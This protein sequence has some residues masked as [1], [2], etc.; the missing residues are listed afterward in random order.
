VQW[1]N[2]KK[3][4]LDTTSDL[5]VEVERGARKLWIAQEVLSKMGEGRK[6][7]DVNNEEE[8]KNNR[9]ALNFCQSTRC[10]SIVLIQAVVCL[11]KVLSLKMRLFFP[12]FCFRV[13]PSLFCS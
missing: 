8:R 3:G 12:H 5:L 13:Q 7:K 9:K 2:L 11:S 6:W 10:H 1:N 4:V